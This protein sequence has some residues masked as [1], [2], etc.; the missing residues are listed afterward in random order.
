VS[1]NV[2]K[3]Q[4][5]WYSALK[6][7]RTT[8]ITFGD[9]TTQSTANGVT[10][11][12]SQLYVAGTTDTIG[13]F[14]IGDTS[15]RTGGFNAPLIEVKRG[16]L[17]LTRGRHYTLNADNVH[18]NGFDPFSAD[19]TDVEV[20]TKV[21]HSPSTAYSPALVPLTPAV[22][23]TFIAYAH[24]IGFAPLMNGG[25]WLSL[26]SYTEDATGYTLTG[27]A[28]GANDDFGAWN[29]TPITLANMLSRNS[30]VIGSGGLTF[31]DGSVQNTAPLSNRNY[32][33]DGNFDSWVNA[34]GVTGS[35]TAITSAAT[36]FQFLTGVGGTA[37]VTGYAQVGADQLTATS[38]VA[39]VAAHNQT[40]AST[41]TVAAGTAPGI[42]QNIEDVRILNARSATF[43]CWLWTTSGSI[44]IPSIFV[45]Q[46]FGT[47]GTP[48][49]EVVSDKAV[50]W[51]VTTTPQRFSVRLDFPTMNGKTLGTNNN[52]YIRVGIWLPPGVTFTVGTNQWQLEQSSLSAPAAGSP[53]PFEYR[54]QQAELAR[55]QRYYST[56]QI[57]MQ[58]YAE[59]ANYAR[60]ASFTF[61]AM[62]AS[63]AISMAITGST[64]AQTMSVV[65]VTS[66][67]GV[68]N[69]NSI[70]AGTVT[71]NSVV[72]TLDARL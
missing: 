15:L 34:G 52:H 70:N 71:V 40:V 60:W 65:G 49:A 45:R 35:A 22:G 42:F 12:V 26:A 66:N 43:S 72:I 46:N 56:V 63:P 32:I 59:Q 27:W 4:I 50:N 6:H 31:A 21:I 11:P 16:G 28:V 58:A 1:D 13:Q 37:T 2:S 18:L 3:W 36:M 23:A 17:W 64:N 47:G 55:V 68:F 19:D 7:I 25:S 38:P 41:G 44:T 24:V 69:A 10:A 8:D 51:V 61:P 57:W 48:A 33:V 9:G 54:G 29:L 67:S 53:T 20:L 5:G 39:M 30:P 62:R 14:A